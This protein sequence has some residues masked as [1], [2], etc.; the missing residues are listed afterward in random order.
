MFIAEFTDGSFK[1]IEIDLQ[2]PDVRQ[3]SD[4]VEVHEIKKTYVPTLTLR[5][6]P[7]AARDDVKS[8]GLASGTQTSTTTS[9]AAPVKRRGRKPAAKKE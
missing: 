8:A 9:N 3:L 5:P 1:P 2:N 4:V 7:K 6:K